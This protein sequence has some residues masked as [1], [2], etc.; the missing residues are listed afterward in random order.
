MKRVALGGAARYNGHSVT[1]TESMQDKG[2]AWQVGVWDHMTAV[3][4][5]EI[6][7]RFVPVIDQV[8]LRARLRPDMRV[9]DV[10]TG[11]GAV[12]LRC[13]P[14][15]SGGEVIGVDISPQMLAIARRRECV[16]P[17]RAS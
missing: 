7:H 16:D 2:L 12:A 10:G 5:Q 4:A 11:T 9:L 17:E 3:Y 6:D 13:S 14:L 8:M 15:V 1:K